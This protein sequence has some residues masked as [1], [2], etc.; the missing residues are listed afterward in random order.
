MISSV[1]CTGNELKILK[2]IFTVLS[3]RRR[4]V[5]GELGAMFSNEGMIQT[6][7]RDGVGTDIQPDH[8]LVLVH[9]IMARC[10]SL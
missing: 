5:G 2:S 6:V 4:K 9:G 3:F 8:L 7:E 10:K 1:L